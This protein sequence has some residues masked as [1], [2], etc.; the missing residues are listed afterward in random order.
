MDG[1]VAGMKV[2]YFD[3]F[4]G[5]SGDMALGALIAAGA[6]VDALRSGLATL[7]VSGW[8]LHVRPVVK[9]GISATDVEVHVEGVSDGHEHEQ[10]DHDHV[11]ETHWHHHHG[12]DHPHDEHGHH[13]HR[14]S[15]TEHRAPSTEHGSA[16]TPA[17]P[18]RRWSDIRT[19]IGESGLPEVVRERATAVFQRLA[20]AEA[21]IH[22]CAVEDVHFHEVG[23]VDSIV[24]I[25]GA[26]LALHLLGVE[27]IVCSP[28][29]TG[30][31]FIRVAHGL[32]PLPAPATLELLRGLP[33]VPSDTEGELVT[34]TGAAL[35]AALAEEWGPM[36][37]MRPEA[38]GYGAGKK[39][40]A[41]PNLLRVCIGTTDVRCQMSDVSG[42]GDPSSLTSD[43]CHLSSVVE[44]TTVTL[45]EANLDDLNPQVYDYVMGRLFAAGALD[46]SLTPIQMKKTRPGVTLSVLCEPTSRDAMAEIVF[47]ETSTLGV[48]YTEWQRI[49]LERDWLTVTTEHGPIR[50]KVGRRDGRVLTVTPEFEE[51]RLAA[52][53]AGA[54]LKDVQM[55][56]AAAARAALSAASG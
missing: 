48:R 52:E 55:A 7:D 51:C 46:V 42:K 21:K 45:L 14:S 8:E 6:D 50:V 31:G 4:S 37:P 35:M 32:M 30:R 54:P 9:H 33:V 2:A 16:A 1:A 10:H 28:L 24:D 17:Q 36:P 38:I 49:C 25:T 3:C 43:I 11:G 41:H 13:H 56:A 19:L 12:H 27:R 18:L 22:G 26:V 20:E 29:P 53:R 23:A 44:A 47:A 40:F 5:I 39:E 15:S 34:P